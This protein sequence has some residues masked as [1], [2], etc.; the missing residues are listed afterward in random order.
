MQ[1]VLGVTPLCATSHTKTLTVIEPN[2]R[3][4]RWAKGLRA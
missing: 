2:D 1:A 4:S 3:V